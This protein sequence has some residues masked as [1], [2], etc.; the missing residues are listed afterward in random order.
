MGQ[1]KKISDI[2]FGAPLGS[3][4][5]SAAWKK[6]V[7]IFL[8]G[9]AWEKCLQGCT[10]GYR[11]GRAGIGA[12]K[13]GW[14]GRLQKVLGNFDGRVCLGKVLARLHERLPGGLG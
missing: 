13:R 9:G 5:A 10:R 1:K 7:E 12:W 4:E 11:V 3:L 2:W 6:C 8:G 14:A